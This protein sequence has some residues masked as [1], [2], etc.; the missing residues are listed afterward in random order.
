MS[1]AAAASEKRLLL[2][3]TSLYDS[4]FSLA[5]H[6]LYLEAKRPPFPTKSLRDILTPYEEVPIIETAGSKEES[7]GE[8]IYNQGIGSLS[9][10]SLVVV[11]L[12]DP[13]NEIMKHASIESWTPEIIEEYKLLA[14]KTKIVVTDGCY[15]VLYSGLSGKSVPRLYAAG[16]NV[17][18]PHFFPLPTLRF[19]C[20]NKELHLYPQIDGIQSESVQAAMIYMVP[21]IQLSYEDSVTLVNQVLNIPT[22]THMYGNYWPNLF[23]KAKTKM[24]ELKQDEGPKEYSLKESL[25]I[26]KESFS[27]PSISP[28]NVNSVDFTKLH[29]LHAQTIPHRFVFQTLI[30]AHY[31]LEIEMNA[32]NPKATE[33][34]LGKNPPILTHK[35]VQ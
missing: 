32:Q 31:V 22:I 1:T 10:G 19:N 23:D 15:L 13:K 14:G 33:L 29:F 21:T 30:K 3:A 26:L 28:S 8:N 20:Q 11:Q 35:L 12:E 34:Q 18:D 6:K 2:L 5:A 25:Q 27:L 17:Y 9:L 24:L 16:E 4:G 7:D